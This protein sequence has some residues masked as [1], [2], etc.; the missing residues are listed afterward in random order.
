MMP[1]Q[2]VAGAVAV[3]PDAF[4]KAFD[5]GHQL[6]SPEVVEILVHGRPLQA[7]VAATARRTSHGSVR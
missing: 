3:G 7:R 4:T 2:V 1:A 5:L 6:V